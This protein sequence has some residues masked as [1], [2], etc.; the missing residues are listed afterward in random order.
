MADASAPSPALQPFQQVLLFRDQG[1][2]FLRRTETLKSPFPPYRQ[3]RR[4]STHFISLEQQNCQ[5]DRESTSFCLLDTQWLVHGFME[6]ETQSYPDGDTV[7]RATDHS[8]DPVGGR[9]G[10]KPTT[11]ETFRSI[12]NTQSDLT[13][14]RCQHR[15]CLTLFLFFPGRHSRESS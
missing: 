1:F 5:P 8:K 3:E 6:A 15:K 2:H 10:E 13:K 9:T 4:A 14:H 11:V 7:S 12:K